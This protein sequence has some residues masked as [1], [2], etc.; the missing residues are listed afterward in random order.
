MSFQHKI[1]RKNLLL[2]ACFRWVSSL[3]LRDL[4]VKFKFAGTIGYGDSYLE[5]LFRLFKVFKFY[6]ILQGAAGEVRAHSGEGP[7]Y[8]YMIERI[9]V[10]LVTLFDYSFAFT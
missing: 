4:E 6:G 10:C 1:A 7:G 3:S 9:H 5:F 8:C 2:K